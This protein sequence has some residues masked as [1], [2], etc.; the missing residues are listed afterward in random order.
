MSL[1]DGEIAALV[2]VG[3]VLAAIVAAYMILTRRRGWM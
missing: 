2:V 1:S 3:G